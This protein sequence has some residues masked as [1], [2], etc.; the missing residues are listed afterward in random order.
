MLI[1]ESSRF[2]QFGCSSALSHQHIRATAGKIA[3]I[4]PTLLIPAWE[5]RRL[6][7]MVSPLLLAALV[8]GCAGKAPSAPQPG[9]SSATTKTQSS[10][11]DKSN[12]PAIDA[13]ATSPSLVSTDERTGRILWEAQAHTLSA[14]SADGIT[15]T[16]IGVRGVLYDRGSPADRIT[17][18]RVNANQGRHTITANGHVVVQSIADAT[19]QVRCD[20]LVWR[21]DAGTLNGSGHVVLTRGTFEQSGNSFEADTRL[22]TLTMPAPSAHG[23]PVHAILQ[24]P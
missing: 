5:S 10:E 16:M 11:H 14:Q 18:D 20:H 13:E 22:K 1:S 7:S 24:L 12:V 17:A 9:I 23:E 4:A 21:A 8:V 15:G 6:C 2:A 3:H 19:T